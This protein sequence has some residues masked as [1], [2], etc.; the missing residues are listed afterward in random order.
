MKTMKFTTYHLRF[1]QRAFRS[2]I[3]FVLSAAGVA[4]ISNL[5][6]RGFATRKATARVGRWNVPTASRLKIGDTAECNSALRR[7]VPLLCVVGFLLFSNARA[8]DQIVEATITVTNVSGIPTNGTATLT[9][10]GATRT[11][12]NNVAANPAVYF[13]GTNSML[14]AKTNLYNHIATYPFGSA[15]TRLTLINIGTNSFK[16]RGQP[17]QTISVSLAG[18]WGTALLSTNTITNFTGVTVPLEYY[19]AAEATNIAYEL[20]RFFSFASNAVAAAATGLSNHLNQF[21]HQTA[22]NKLFFASTNNAGAIQNARQITGTNVALTNVT[23]SVASVSAVTSFSGTNVLATN[24]T[25]RHFKLI[26]GRPEGTNAGITNGYTVGL[27][28]INSASSNHVNYGDALRSEGSGPNSLQLGSNANAT[29]LRAIVVGNNSTNSGQDGAAFG[30]ETTNSATF[31]SVMGNRSSVSGLGSAALGSANHVSGAASYAVGQAIKLTNA[32]QVSVGNATVNSG[33]NTLSVGAQAQATDTSAAAF[34]FQAQATRINSL[35]LGPAASAAHS[36]SAALGPPDHTGTAVATTRSNQIVTGTAQ[37]TLYVPGALS[38]ENYS[39]VTAM[40]GSTN[41]F[42]AGSDISF[43]RFAITTV[44]NGHNTLNVGTNVYID[45][46]GSPTA[47]WT[48]GGIT[49]GNRDGKLIKVRN[50]TG[51]PADILHN[52]GTEPTASLRISTP[53]TTSVTLQALGWAEFLYDPSASRWQLVDVFN[54]A[55]PVASATNAVTQGEHLGL[56]NSTAMGVF[57]QVQG[58]T[59]IQFRTIRGGDLVTL[60]NEGTN[61]TVAAAAAYALTLGSAGSQNPADSAT[62]YYGSDLNANLNTTWDLTS[63]DV[64]KSGALKRVFIKVRV[65]GT[66][67]SGEAVSHYVRINDTTDVTLDTTATYNTAVTNV[68]ANVSQ[69]VAA[70]DRLAI[71]IATPAWATNPTGVRIYAVLYIE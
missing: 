46:T 45:L 6:Y 38:A 52:S 20:T 55:T 29:A 48:W 42:P 53:T 56:T 69:A 1:A 7:L 5:L 4:Q 39:N 34:G 3:L 68:I 9:V 64:P 35:A 66:L 44:A 70:G 43:G 61:I 31:G 41:R 71:K 54:T 63:V 62:Y 2:C 25:L 21:L 33:D 14:H 60:T 58:Q 26:D 23:L 10:N 57:Y 67:G 16:L 59:N 32:Q 22:S 30:N 51:W 19:S 65:T 40:V 49:G 8:A 47:P 15:G 37:Q 28:N 18:L 13:L 11:A 24:V 27:T 12:T 17:N 50:A 36:N